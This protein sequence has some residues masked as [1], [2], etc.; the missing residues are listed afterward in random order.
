MQDI[1]SREIKTDEVKMDNI[2]Q[3]R[4]NFKAS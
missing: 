4:E 1:R 2:E 3:R